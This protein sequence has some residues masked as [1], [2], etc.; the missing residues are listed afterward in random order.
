MWSLVSGAA[1]C[2]T[3]NQAHGCDHETGQSEEALY[4][5]VHLSSLGDEQ[6]KVN[7]K[8]LHRQLLKGQFTLWEDLST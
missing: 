6:H 1:L 8:T 3:S 4:L 2:V 5:G 7:I